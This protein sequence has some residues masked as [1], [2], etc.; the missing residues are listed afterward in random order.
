[1]Y[2]VSLATL[3]TFMQFPLRMKKLYPLSCDI[4]RLSRM[5]VDNNLY[6]T[7]LFPLNLVVTIAIILL[8]KK[9][10]LEIFFSTL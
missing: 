8:P 9:K 4:V 2:G 6:I 5:L 1:M 10:N 7:S 3:F